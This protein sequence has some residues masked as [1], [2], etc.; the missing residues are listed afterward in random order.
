MRPADRQSAVQMV[1]AADVWVLHGHSRLDV[2]PFGMLHPATQ[3]H[4]KEVEP[5]AEWQDRDCAVRNDPCLEAAY[6]LLVESCAGVCKAG[7]TAVH[8]AGLD[9][10]T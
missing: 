2:G 5:Q 10:Q 7:G 8:L 4:H 6:W 1:A 3:S 9:P